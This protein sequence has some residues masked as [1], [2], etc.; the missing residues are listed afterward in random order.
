MKRLLITLWLYSCGVNL[1]AQ[2]YSPVDA[3]SEVKFLIKNF[4]LNVT[5]SFKGLQ[6]TVV[7]DPANPAAASVDVSVDAA[8]VNTSNN[9]RDKHLKK[10]EYFDVAKY[11]KLTFVSL[12]ISATGKPGMYNMEGY[13]SIKG[14]AKLVSFPFT[15]ATV[16]NGYR[17]TGQFRIKRRDF[18]VGGGSWVL[19]DDLT[20]LLNVMAIKQ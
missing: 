10:E 7:F 3:G 11:P 8:T 12:K 4:G 2:N 19:S 18:K 15:A 13:L 5:G 9:A 14:T 17:L 20:V 1:F 16:A 6:G